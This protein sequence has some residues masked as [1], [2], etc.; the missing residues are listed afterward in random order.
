MIDALV[1]AVIMVIATAGL[2]LAVEVGNRAMSRA[3]RHPLN[4][5]E[6]ELV[7]SIYPDDNQK[8]NNLQAD[9]ESLPR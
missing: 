4:D 7:K 3:G 2:V 6:R 1:G 9:L 8:L 5:A